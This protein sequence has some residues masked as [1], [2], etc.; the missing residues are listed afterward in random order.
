MI[1][2]EKERDRGRERDG[3]WWLAFGG[4]FRADVRP[5]S[6]GMRDDE[7][8]QGNPPCQPASAYFS[9][10]ALAINTA[11]PG[12]LPG[13]NAT[14]PP[15]PA[16]P[17]ARRVPRRTPP[18]YSPRTLP[19]RLLLL[20]YLSTCAL[21]STVTNQPPL[22]I[23]RF[24]APRHLAIPFYAYLRMCFPPLLSLSLPL[25]SFLLSLSPLPS[26]RICLENLVLCN[27]VHLG[28]LFCICLFTNYRLFGVWHNARDEPFGNP[29]VNKA[30]ANEVQLVDIVIKKNMIFETQ[31]YWKTQRE[32]NINKICSRY[33]V[34]LETKYKELL[35]KNK[36]DTLFIRVINGCV[37]QKKQLCSF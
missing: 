36:W 13:P 25:P 2:R 6:W 19:P 16:V 24:A 1:G 31:R 3:E 34:Y 29:A 33:I 35:M 11:S 10:L 12:E 4:G 18:L 26:R 15:S 37:Q 22:T 20:T 8:C 5:D 21:P 32:Y 30:M 7:G 17:A 23:P 27:A 9:P 14:P 28:R